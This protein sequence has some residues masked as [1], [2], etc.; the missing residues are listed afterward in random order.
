M[1]LLRFGGR[2]RRL[3]G[4]IPFFLGVLIFSRFPYYLAA[5]AKRQ[6]K[7]ANKYPFW[8]S[9]AKAQFRV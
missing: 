8:P 6:A 4:E 5:A 7:I 2:P 1:A 3:F 9:L